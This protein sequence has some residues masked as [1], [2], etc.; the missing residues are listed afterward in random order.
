VTA[1]PDAAF[2]SAL[3]IINSVWDTRM[4]EALQNLLLL[5]ISN[6]NNF[7]RSDCSLQSVIHVKS[8][9]VLFLYLTVPAL[10]P[11]HIDD[12]AYAVPF[13]IPS[14]HS[15]QALELAYLLIRFMDKYIRDSDYTRFQIISFTFILDREGTY[16]VLIL[17]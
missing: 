7:Y 10:I 13:F 11:Y 16:G 5:L 15:F 6:P 9:S 8:I 17:D 1:V 12:N 3:A 2:E 14:H 4:Y